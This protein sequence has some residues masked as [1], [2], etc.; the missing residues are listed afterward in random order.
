M[1][2]WPAATPAG[3]GLLD[4]LGETAAD[5]DVP[6]RVAPERE[7]EALAREFALTDEELT[8][9]DRHA[10]KGRETARLAG[11]AIVSLALAPKAL[12]DRRQLDL[13]VRAAVPPRQVRETFGGN[14][15]RLG[16]PAVQ[17]AVPRQRPVE[18]RPPEGSR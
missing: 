12:R 5:A 10:Q 4:T 15:N 6:G 3:R 17:T 18:R 2:G 7:V 8:L 9:A 16:L 1:A 14:R 11:N 13:E